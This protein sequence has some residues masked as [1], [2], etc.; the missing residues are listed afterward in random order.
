MTSYSRPLSN[1]QSIRR[2]RIRIRWNGLRLI[3]YCFNIRRVRIVLGMTPSLRA[4]GF[5]GN[6]AGSSC[7]EKAGK[8]FP[9]ASIY[10]AEKALQRDSQNIFHILT[11]DLQKAANLDATQIHLLPGGRGIIPFISWPPTIAFWDARTC[12]AWHSTVLS[13]FTTDNKNKPKGKGIPD[14]WTVCVKG[15]HTRYERYPA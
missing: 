5:E 1:G 6:R 4:D 8:P 10:Y 9:A 14:G 13:G 2:S 11:E 12:S 15:F 3:P 7:M